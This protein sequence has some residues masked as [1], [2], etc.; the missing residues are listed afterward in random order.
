MQGNILIVDDQQALAGH[1][2][3]FL[4]RADYV[5]SLAHTGAKARQVMAEAVPDLV[6][7]DLKLPD[8]DGSELMTELLEPYPDTS[9]IIITAYGS[10][11]SAVE[12][13]RSGAVDYLTKPFE[14]E[15]MLLAVQHALRDRA[16]DAELQ[17]RRERRHSGV[18]PAVGDDL[19][20]ARS[21]SM[22]RVMTFARRAAAQDGIVL[23][24]GH[25]GTG[26]D[27][28]ARVIHDISARA[29]GP[30]FSINCSTL[31][32]ELAES[33][34]FGH[35]PGAFTGS[36]RR[37]LGLLE[38]AR[39]GTLL[40]NEVGELD[41]SLQ[42][43]LLSFL[44][45]RTFMR[46]GGVHSIRISARLMAATNRDL[47]REVAA[48]RFREDLFYR[49]NVFPIELPPLSRRVE[50]IP[51]LAA[52]L[53]DA[54]AIEMG[55][56]TRPSVEPRALE[57]LLAYDWPGNIRELRNVLE[58]ALILSGRPVVRRADLKLSPRSESFEVRVGFEPGLNLEEVTRNVTRELV[59]EALRRAKTR[60]EAA[61]LLGISRFAL[62]RR[63]KALGLDAEG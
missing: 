3:T 24:L 47:E 8:A 41:L 35:E 5:V 54:I 62:N 60:N 48:G 20:T 10:I 45:T 53:L 9:F 32:K 39:E 55:L 21:P 34:L 52:V 49:L 17:S 26:K 61:E 19:G 28:L 16:K 44:D 4:R 22:R 36:R 31:P 18:E 29:K 15:E 6:L 13:T 42:A 38:L 58:R 50:D 59:S 27:H 46:V 51:Q 12:A 23:L 57:A 40:L 25:S 56:A 7:M 14:P 63:L 2:A 43:K 30:F 1:L 37:K 33:E 11:R